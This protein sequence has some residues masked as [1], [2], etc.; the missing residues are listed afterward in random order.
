M[1]NKIENHF[2]LIPLLL[3]R[4]GNRK[5]YLKLDERKIISRILSNVRAK[6]VVRIV[7]YS[8]YMYIYIYLRG[9]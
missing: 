6:I 5:M 1:K 4:E 8:K 7:Q 3:I 9:L 2:L